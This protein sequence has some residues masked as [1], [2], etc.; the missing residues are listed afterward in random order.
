MSKFL[1]HKEFAFYG[2]QLVPE[3]VDGNNKAFDWNEWLSKTQNE[4]G[5]SIERLCL[6]GC[7]IL[8]ISVWLGF[9]FLIF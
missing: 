3:I 2:A 4:S 9:K 7:L 5:T 6:D 1:E 8:D